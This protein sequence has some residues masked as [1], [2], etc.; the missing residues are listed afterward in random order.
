MPALNDFEKWNKDNRTAR[1]IMLS[2]MHFELVPTYETYSTAK[3]MWDALKEEY[4]E[5][6]TGKACVMPME[7]DA[8][9]MAPSVNLRNHLCKMSEM[10]ADLT[11][12]GNVLTKDQKIISVLR[13]LPN[14][15]HIIK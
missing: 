13:S 8:Y 14:S 12:A 9:R 4:G 15:W 7:F 3:E 1:Y 10:I 6:A 2:S 5:I 11:R